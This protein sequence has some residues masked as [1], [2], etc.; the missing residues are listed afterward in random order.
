[1]WEKAGQTRDKFHC[2]FGVLYTNQWVQSPPVVA[3]RLF[4]LIST[5]TNAASRYTD[6]ATAVSA[7]D[8]AGDAN[9]AV[10]AKSSKLLSSQQL[11]FAKAKEVIDA[12]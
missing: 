11:Q 3:P 2:V 8:G 12:K 1:M 10:R 5:Q 4:I 7:A 6:Q 9:A